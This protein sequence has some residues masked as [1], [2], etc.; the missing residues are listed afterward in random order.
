MRRFVDGYYAKQQ[1]VTA[2]VA[3]TLD[4]DKR[5]IDGLRRSLA[6]DG[7]RDSLKMLPDADGRYLRDPSVLFTGTAIFDTEHKRPADQAPTTG[8]TT[9]A[10]LFLPLPSGENVD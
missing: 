10:H 6:V 5:C 2:M 4:E 1:P 3:L 7:V 9:L 8:S